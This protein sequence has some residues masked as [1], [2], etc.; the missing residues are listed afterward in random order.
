MGRFYMKVI[1]CANLLY[2]CLTAVLVIN[3]YPSLSILGVS[4]FL[5]ELVVIGLLIYLEY[6][7]IKQG[8]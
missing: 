4:Y 8:N 2:C 1:A 7:V 6:E 5:G 3:F